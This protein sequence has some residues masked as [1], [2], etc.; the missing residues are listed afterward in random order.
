MLTPSY[1]HSASG[2]TL[3]WRDSGVHPMYLIQLLSCSRCG[4]RHRPLS[5]LPTGKHSGAEQACCAS[6]RDHPC[7]LSTAH[8]S[9]QLRQQAHGRRQCRRGAGCHPGSPATHTAHVA[10]LDDARTAGCRPRCAGSTS[11]PPGTWSAAC[12]CCNPRT[13]A[14]APPRHLQFKGS[15]GRKG[16]KQQSAACQNA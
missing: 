16:R 14:P 10:L 11:P 4:R 12:R 3:R 1:V 8:C 7:D 2:R 9:C 15:K 13:A 5:G 6:E